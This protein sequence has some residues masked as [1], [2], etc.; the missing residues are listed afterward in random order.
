M[1]NVAFILREEAFQDIYGEECL[2]AVAP[3]GRVLGPPISAETLVA[4]PPAWLGEVEVLF[5]GWGAPRLDADLLRRLPRLRAVFYGAGSLRSIATDACWERG[6]VFASA[7]ALNAVPVVE[8]TLGAILLSFKRV[9]HQSNWVKS[10]RAYEPLR[11]LP[12]PTGWGATVG[13]VSLGQIGAGVA[14]RLRDFD[15]KLLAHDPLL[16]P[17]RCA[18][19]G[20]ESVSLEEI[21]SRSDILSLHTPLLPETAGLVNRRLLDL[22][23]PN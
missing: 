21:F 15:V 5:T 12:V 6:I 7:A 14:V 1:I 20:A 22:L 4:R 13:L 9:W 3:A 18:E 10:Q 19:L 17:E 11:P 23:R 16:P 2:R 8:F